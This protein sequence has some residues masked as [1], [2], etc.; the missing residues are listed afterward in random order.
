MDRDALCGNI[1][2]NLALQVVREPETIRRAAHGQAANDGH[3]KAAAVLRL[4]MPYGPL[5]PLSEVNAAGTTSLIQTATDLAAAIFRAY[6]QEEMFWRE[7]EDLP[8]GSQANR[9]LLQ[10]WDAAAGKHPCTIHPFTLELMD[11]GCTEEAAAKELCGPPPRSR[12]RS[13]SCERQRRARAA[14]EFCSMVR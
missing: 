3:P 7:D 8:Q 4:S 13:R 12:S 14:A 1:L 10:L 9:L 2:M 6:W 5:R 11:T